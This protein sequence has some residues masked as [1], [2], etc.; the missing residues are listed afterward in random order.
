M[1]HVL[2]ESPGY[3]YEKMAEHLANRIA[4]GEL[5]PH[6][7]LPAEKK[8]ALE[9][10]VSLG[11]ARHATRLLQHRGLVITIRSKGSYVAR[12]QPEQASGSHPR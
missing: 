3:I 10:G 6:T 11:T 9:Y 8:L 2:D 5:T 12:Q 4:A 1:S 7:P